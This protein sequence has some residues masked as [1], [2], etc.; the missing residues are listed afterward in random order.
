MNAI[1][2]PATDL[3]Q[4][5]GQLS[6]SVTRPIPGSR[7]IFIEGSRPDIQVPMREYLDLPQALMNELALLKIEL[8]GLPPDAA[9]FAAFDPFAIPIMLALHDSCVTQPSPYGNVAQSP[10]SRRV[11]PSRL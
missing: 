3:L 1:P 5:T 11:K 10:R 2:K 9:Q 6:E 8:V 4:Q 7:K